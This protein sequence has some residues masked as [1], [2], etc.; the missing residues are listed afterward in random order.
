MKKEYKVEIVQEGAISTIFF[1]ASKLP[2][3]KMEAV[4]NAYGK[5]GW[6]MDFMVMEH[7]RLFLLWSRE[8]A[9]LTFSRPLK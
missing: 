4:M 3:E 1:A 7:R 2:V 9:V 6:N 8:A 5:E